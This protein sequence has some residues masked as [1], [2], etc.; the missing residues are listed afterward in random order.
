MIEYHIDWFIQWDKDK[1]LQN[2]K[3]T[4]SF[5]TSPEYGISYRP[6][7]EYKVEV[8]VVNNNE[9]DSH[10]RGECSV[11]E[12]RVSDT[13]QLYPVQDIELVGLTEENLMEIKA[14]LDEHFLQCRRE[15]DIYYKE[16]N[17]E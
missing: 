12:Y 6:I 3:Y 15:F 16:S 8:I 17:D 13:V 14:W 1:K 2:A 7:F 9:E 4:G 10:L 5:G 11:K